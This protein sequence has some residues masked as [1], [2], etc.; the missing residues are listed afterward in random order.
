MATPYGSQLKTFL[1]DDQPARQQ[2][3]TA[4]PEVLR[5]GQWVPLYDTYR[6]HHEATPVGEAEFRQ[7]LAGVKPAPS[8]LGDT[9]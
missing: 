1:L 8:R 2:S 6:F 7:A 5:Q 3:P 4:V 9:R